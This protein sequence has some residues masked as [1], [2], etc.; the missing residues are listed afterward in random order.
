LI[1]ELLNVTGKKLFTYP[2][3]TIAPVYHELS[4]LGVEIVC[5]KAEQG[6]GYMAIA[7]AIL[8]GTPSFVA[9]TSGPGVTN[10]VTCVADAF[11]DSIPVVFFTGQV[12]TA[13]LARPKQLRQRGFQ[14]VPTTEML[15][16]VTKKT[17]QPK[18]VNELKDSLIEGYSLAAT[19]RPG[20]VVI[21]LPMDMQ[22]TEIADDD[23]R[24]FEPFSA[25]QESAGDIQTAD[26]K[27]KKVVDCLLSAESPI[28]L[29]GGGAASCYESVRRLS[30]KLSIPVVSSFRGIGIMPSSHPLFFGWIG[31][32][33]FPGANDILFNSDC[34]LVLGSRLD[35]RQTGSVVDEFQKK[36]I[37]HIDVD[38]H[39]ITSGRFKPNVGIHST[40][41]NF[42]NGF[43][44]IL[45]D[46]IAIGKKEWLER[47]RNIAK[48]YS[49]G[50]AG[51]I[52][53]VRPDDLL[54]YVDEQTINMQ[55]AIVTG[56]GSHQQW[57]GRHF[58]YDIP[59]KLFFTSAGHGTMG[60]GLPV[61][62]GVKFQQPERLVICIDGD[63]SFQMNLQ[64]LA[65]IKEYGLSIKI[66]VMD[67]SRLGIVSQ[68][69]QITFGDDP[70][71]G[72]FGGPDF[73]VIARGYGV[74]SWKIETFC[75]E[76][77]DKWLEYDGA[78]LLHAKI[79]HDAPVSP[80]LLAG[81]SLNAMWES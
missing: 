79:Q 5:S 28:I 56:V 54:E 68:F 2:G 67:N 21:D 24:G 37:I 18:T 16:A 25:N 29:V 27:L 44:P 62:L 76:T 30:E 22:L 70:V 41:E 74:K 52:Q 48:Q 33:G 53:G 50:D 11:Y 23:I 19:G 65:L 59:N 12:G 1:A 14:E 71:A 26:K 8:T 43:I 61:A 63:G 42:I 17:Y 77:I 10:I 69:Q 7:D 3:G 60:Y 32:T 80:M 55:T 64:E 39:E 20:P 35:I 6:A 36:N 34:V 46:Q 58:S 45:D 51:R 57:A 13:D 72:E 73:S 4:R 78:A 66:L 9:V 49:F 31:H 40:V 15:E 38:R 81:Q 75:R 47:A